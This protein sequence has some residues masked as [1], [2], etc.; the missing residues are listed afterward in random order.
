MDSPLMT[1]VRLLSDAKFPE[2]RPQNIAVHLH[3][4]G[5][6]TDIKKRL[7]DVVAQQIAAQLPV[8]PIFVCRV[9]FRQLFL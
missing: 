3:L 2:N 5:Q 6:L 7:P 8:Q 9:H 4:T 1:V